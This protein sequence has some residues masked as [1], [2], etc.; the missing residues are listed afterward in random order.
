M[1]AANEGGGGG[2]EG[3]GGEDCPRL[4]CNCTSLTSSVSPMNN[5]Y[6]LSFFE[7]SPF[8]TKPEKP[9]LT[10]K[11]MPRVNKIHQKAAKAL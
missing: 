1:S 3:R 9:T 6:C 7:S 10:Q 8:F 11:T 2:G 4:K 5:A